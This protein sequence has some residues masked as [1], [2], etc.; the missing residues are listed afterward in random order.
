MN[1]KFFLIL[2]LSVSAYLTNSTAQSSLFEWTKQIGG[3]SN[4]FATAVELDNQ[5]NIYCTGA[6]SDTT[7][8]ADSVFVTGFDNVFISKFL[9]NGQ[10][11]WIR[12][13]GGI[14]SDRGL[15]LKIDNNNNVI[16]TGYFKNTAT[17]GDTTLTSLGYE[18]VF[19]VKYTSEGDFEWVVHGAG[20]NRSE[21]LC[22]AI[23][24]NNNIFISG[25]FEAS[26][27]ISSFNLTAPDIA[28]MFLA[29][30]AEDGTVLWAE[31]AGGQ[32]FSESTSNDLICDNNG[33][34][35]VTGFFNESF[36]IQDTTLYS[37]DDSDDI[38]IIK[39]DTNGNK[40]W[41]VQAG[42]DNSD[43]ATAI[44]TDGPGNI[45]VT[46]QFRGTATFGSFTLNTLNNN[47]DVFYCK[48]NS[49][50][51]F[52]WVKQSTGM[53]TDSPNSI[54]YNSNYG[55]VLCGSYEGEFNIGDSTF[56]SSGAD[57]IFLFSFGTEG[58]FISAISLGEPA[59]DDVAYDIYLDQNNKA[60]LIGK[61]HHSILI[62]DTLLVSYGL[63]D[64]FITKIN[65][66]QI[67]EVE[68]I[69]F[70]QP[71]LIHLHQNYPNPFNPNTVIG[72][73]LPVNGNVT[74]KIYDFLG[75]E[76]TTLV[77]EYMPAGIYEVEFQSAVG[78]RQ[79]ASGIY[80]YQLKVFDRESGSGQVFVQTKKM[81]LIK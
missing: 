41:I 76:I 28:T 77:D 39:Y 62:G 17:F 1:I 12:I 7:Y 49:L 65:L 46:G 22:L 53:L 61:F 45:Y 36:I 19:V 18:D 26:F 23:D 73:Q 78:N 70:V 67:N 58:T 75:N 68:Y 14:W 29:K 10:L 74:L 27:S 69:S 30:I 8:F 37:F 80:F 60:Y 31:Q 72:Y 32:Q 47:I 51:V 16:V 33:H 25:Y 48:I 50:G 20:T 6:I 66:D 35:I 2:Y 9:P 11:D 71:D 3:N 40:V 34:V 54:F 81:L 52:E 59:G 56:N 55:L 63:A 64:V 42:G 57:D 21:G 79:L 44:T 15:D 5:G 24:L 38:F 4:E 13:C 43:L